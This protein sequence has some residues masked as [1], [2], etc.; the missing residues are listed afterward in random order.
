MRNVLGT[1]LPKARDGY[2]HQKNGQRVIQFHV[3]V[4]DILRIDFLNTMSSEELSD[5][6]QILKEN[7]CNPYCTKLIQVIDSILLLRMMIA[8]AD[9]HPTR[10]HR[11]P[12]I[13]FQRG[14]D[15]H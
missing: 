4:T 2:L 12:D 3:T 15:N 11:M 9:M 14:I 5:S 7:E 1:E 8:Y 10:G 13:M 6:L